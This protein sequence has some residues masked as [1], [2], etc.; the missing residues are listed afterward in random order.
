[1]L[2]GSKG[3]KL[4]LGS[5]YIEFDRVAGV[6]FCTLVSI[7]DQPL[8]SFLRRLDS[9][10]RPCASC[11]ATQ[12]LSHSLPIPNNDKLVIRHHGHFAANN[13]DRLTWQPTT[14]NSSRTPRWCATQHDHVFMQYTLLR[15]Y[16]VATAAFLSDMWP[17]VRNDRQIQKI[18]PHVRSEDQ[19]LPANSFVVRMQCFWQLRT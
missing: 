18:Q 15:K 10:Q 8:V 6:S 13:T 1:M 16:P 14:Y 17:T 19:P 11:P 12:S 4:G 7:C 3:Q 9:N 2:L 5:K